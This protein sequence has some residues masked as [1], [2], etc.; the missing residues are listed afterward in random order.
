MKNSNPGAARRA[1]P[2]TVGLGLGL[3]W[4]LAIACPT[5]PSASVEA[6]TAAAAMQR[7][8]DCHPDVLAARDA[9]RGAAADVT[10]AGQAPNPQ[11]TVGA[12]SM[13]GARGGIG[14]G[15]LW[16]K[17]FDHQL[18]VDQLLERGGKAE[19]RRAAA[20][21]QREAA[22]LTLADTLRQA[23][24]GVARLHA[25]LW[26]AQA[27]VQA[28]SDSVQASE[29]SLKALE[30]RVAA[31]DAPA[32]DV[33]R[34][35]ADHARAQ[36]DL[37]QARGDA[38]A[39]QIQLAA[40]IG[41]LPQ[42][43]R[44]QAERPANPETTT[45]TT[46]EAPPTASASPRAGEAEVER[47]AQ[48]ADLQAAEQRLRAAEHSRDVA[49]ALRTRDVNVGLQVDHYP[50]SAANPSGSGNTLSVSVSVPLMVRHAYDGEIA[51]A[52]AD[53]DAA[54][55]AYERSRELALADLQRLRGQLDAAQT[56]YR[57]AATELEPAATQLAT[58]LERAYQR[59][60]VG[61]LELLEARRNQRAAQVERITA[62]AE[63]A[64]ARADWAAALRLPD[65][66]SSPAALAP[67]SSPVA[68][69]AAAR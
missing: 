24:A 13:S 38:R 27:R 53:V 23:E 61:S 50:A 17:T 59:G 60:G 15:S 44:L 25:D 63:Q 35:R 37:Q 11:L 41:A 12:G 57:L 67:P 5:L 33:M 6:L 47:L 39:L 46:P 3:G 52:Q 8:G 18:R 51:R 20:T 14:G 32:A 42:A 1:G 34:F 22:R 40:A 28:L 10:T 55:N 54:R 65:D 69:P 2:L 7:V 31:G 64:K 58:A 4:S 16:S 26:A 9:L 48:R 68:A 19:A 56:R 49:Q 43:D 30:R 66:A 36:A 62:E 29:Q 45:E 21:A